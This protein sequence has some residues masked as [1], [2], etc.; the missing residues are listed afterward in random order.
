MVTAVMQNSRAASKCL[1]EALQVCLAGCPGVLRAVQ[2]HSLTV[3]HQRTP[4]LITVNTSSPSVGLTFGFNTSL[5]SMKRGHTGFAIGEDVGSC[6][7][8]TERLTV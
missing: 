6:T 4:D 5:Q 8:F 3:S 7:T 1:I 2:T